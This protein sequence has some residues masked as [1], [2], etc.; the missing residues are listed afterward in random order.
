MAGSD[1]PTSLMLGGSKS[2]TLVALFTG[3]LKALHVFCCAG[4]IA[5]AG[6]AVEAGC[7][8]TTVGPVGRCSVLGEQVLPPNNGGRLTRAGKRSHCL[9]VFLRGPEIFASS[10]SPHLTHS[11]GP[12]DAELALAVGDHFSLFHAPSELAGE[13]AGGMARIG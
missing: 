13:R 6:P 3:G 12:S 7:V 1:G 4:V 11:Q 10:F 5:T 9:H 8:T 2:G